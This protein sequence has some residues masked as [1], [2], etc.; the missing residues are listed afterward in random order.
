ME[1]V[2]LIENIV[3]IR[4]INAKINI[5]KFKR[6]RLQTIF[7]SVVILIIKVKNKINVII[8]INVNFV[9][10]YILNEE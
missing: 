4:S 3:E 10:S 6:F 7:S 8:C 5:G 2:G 1:I 9:N